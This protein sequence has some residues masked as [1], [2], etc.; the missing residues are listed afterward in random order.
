MPPSRHIERAADA[1]V[2]YV[3]DDIESDILRLDH[4]FHAITMK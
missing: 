2:G 1:H 4:K 3:G